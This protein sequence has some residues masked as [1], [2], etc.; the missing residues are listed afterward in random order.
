M[1]FKRVLSLSLV[2]FSFISIFSCSVTE[3]ETNDSFQ[4]NYVHYELDTLGV[5]NRT[6][7]VPYVVNEYYTYKDSNQLLIKGYTESGD[8]I[9]MVFIRSEKR[10]MTVGE[11]EV[12]SSLWRFN[13]T[14]WNDG[15]DIYSASGKSRVSEVNSRIDFTFKGV[16][17]NSVGF[18]RYNVENGIGLNLDLYNPA[19][20]TIQ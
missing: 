10:E 2:L 17:S 4:W 11:Y 3:E 8:S 9:D 14:L 18:D 16:M 20:D 1:S 19:S 5:W 6:S 15:M 12:G 13:F 7:S